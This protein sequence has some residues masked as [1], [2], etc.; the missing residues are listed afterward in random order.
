MPRRQAHRPA[1]NDDADE[2]RE[3]ERELEQVVEQVVLVREEELAAHGRGCLNRV[4]TPVLNIVAG[5]PH[6]VRCKE[7]VEAERLRGELSVSAMLHHA[8]AE[9]PAAMLD[10][11][12]PPA[13]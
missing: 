5:E 2:A 13:R 1:P 7:A 12:P 8:A 3:H 9:I 11:P 10:T 6:G 4:L